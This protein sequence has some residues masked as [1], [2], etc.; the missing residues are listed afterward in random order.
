MKSKIIAA[1][2]VVV[3]LLSLLACATTPQPV[4]V[5]DSYSG[6]EVQIATGGSLVVTLESNVTTGFKWELSGVTDQTVL[7]QDGEPEYV[8]PA[9]SALGAGG[10]EVWTFKALKAGTS[11]I[12][13]AY[14]RPWERGEKGVNTFNLTVVV[15]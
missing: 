6:K 15:K 11:T 3:V 13:M 8:P 7:Q 10:T 9:A 4:S 2:L 5:D 14:S 1:G 12:S